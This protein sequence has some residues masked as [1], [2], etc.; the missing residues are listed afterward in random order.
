MDIAKLNQIKNN[1]ENTTVSKK[2]ILD[3]LKVADVKYP[4]SVFTHLKN[5]NVISTLARN[6]YRFQKE[7]ILKVMVEAGE[8]EAYKARKKYND[9][10]YGSK[11]TT[12]SLEDAEKSAIEL[13]KKKGYRIF[14]YVE[15]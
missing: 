3:V 12:D 14:K 1:L 8:K 15:I 6:Q 7:P 5:A 13:L 2:Q 10:Y 9:R 4:E 11:D